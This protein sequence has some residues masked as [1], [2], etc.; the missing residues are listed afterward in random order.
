MEYLGLS[1][2]STRGVA[3]ATSA[4]GD[5]E[6]IVLAEEELELRKQRVETGAVEIDKHVETEHVRESVPVMREEVTVER[7]PVTEPT[8]TEAHFDG[9]EIRIPIVEEEVVIEKRAVVKEELVIHKD[10]VQ[11]QHV[12]E[13]DLRRERGNAPKRRGKPRA[14]DDESRDRYTPVHGQDTDRDSAR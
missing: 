14:G 12:V 8:N 4:A 6:R 13:A 7:R 11:D 5:E 9:D 3:A 1:G 2:T 10:Q